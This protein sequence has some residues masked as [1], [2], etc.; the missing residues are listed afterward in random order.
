MNRESVGSSGSC[1]YLDQH[2]LEQGPVLYTNDIA[3]V[4]HGLVNP[5]RPTVSGNRMRRLER[6]AS[7]RDPRNRRIDHTSVSVVRSNS[8][9]EGSTQSVGNAHGRYLELLSE[10]VICSHN[11]CN[12]GY[13]IPRNVRY[14]SAQVFTN[15]NGLLRRSHSSNS[16]VDNDDLSDVTDE[17]CLA[18]ESVCASPPSLTNTILSTLSV[19]AMRPS[20]MNHL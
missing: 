5:N 19:S 16:Q 13:E 18:N 7:V 11:N 3:A 1:S 15:S 4:L 2:S 20:E 14:G 17:S 8:T 9:I 6:C 12:D 10:P